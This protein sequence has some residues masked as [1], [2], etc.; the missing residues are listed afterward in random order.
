MRNFPPQLT[1]VPCLDGVERE[2]GHVHGRPRRAACLCAMTRGELIV[3]HG[4][5][6]TF[7]DDLSKAMAIRAPPQARACS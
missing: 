3:S 7:A 1:N 2:K 5:A 4:M 6:P